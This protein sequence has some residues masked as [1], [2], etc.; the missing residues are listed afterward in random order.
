MKQSPNCLKLLR[1]SI[2]IWARLLLCIKLYLISPSYF[3]VCGRR[4]PYVQR[5]PCGGKMSRRR[6]KEFESHF[7][8]R[9]KSFCFESSISAIRDTK[10]KSKKENRKMVGKM[11]KQST[12]EMIN[13]MQILCQ[14]NLRA[15]PH[16]LKFPKSIGIN[17]IAREKIAPDRNIPQ[18][19]RHRRCSK[20]ICQ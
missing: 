2:P 9:D 6:R 17:L 4:T 15:L 16:Q 8:V 5:F 14:F 10:T 18:N 1:I 3:N 7:W 20:I 13:F 19:A 11:V 12:C